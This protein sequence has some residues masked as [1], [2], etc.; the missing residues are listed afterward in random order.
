M[1]RT[2]IV[3]RRAV[4]RHAMP[5]VAK[6][7]VAG[8][9]VT[10]GES[11]RRPVRT[12]IAVEVL[13]VRFHRFRSCERRPKQVRLEIPRSIDRPLE[14][15]HDR[16]EVREFEH[17]ELEFV[18]VGESLG[19]EGAELPIVDADVGSVRIRPDGVE[20]TG[21]L[22]PIE[23]APTIERAAIGIVLADRDQK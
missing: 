3:P 17:A 6:E 22:T 12:R 9:L 7:L 13:Q 11:R 10:D 20:A 18:G 19:R 23:V 1:Q 21:I 2:N 15:T 5:R 8:E 4:R 16:S 14:R